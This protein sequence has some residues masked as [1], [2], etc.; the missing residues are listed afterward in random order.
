[1]E[2]K[3]E[4][5][6]PGSGQVFTNE[7]DPV[8]GKLCTARRETIQQQIK[9]LDSKV[10]YLFGT[11]LVVIALGIASLILQVWRGH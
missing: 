10:T 2:E 3:E 4:Q 7:L 6:C 1:M 11:S 8:S 9:A 5:D